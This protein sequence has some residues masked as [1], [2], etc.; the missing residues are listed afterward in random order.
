MKPRL[1]VL[2]TSEPHGGGAHQYSLSIVEALERFPR[3][4]Y[5]IVVVYANKHWETLLSELN[6]DQRFQPAGVGSILLI[7]LL[8]FGLLPVPLARGALL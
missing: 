6:L 4:E 7:K 1:G 8:R 3:N 2:L 5:D